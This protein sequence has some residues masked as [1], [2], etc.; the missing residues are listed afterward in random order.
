MIEF[1]C[2]VPVSSNAFGVCGSSIWSQKYAMNTLCLTQA[3]THPFMN[4]SKD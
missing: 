1:D 2:V 4:S 3:L